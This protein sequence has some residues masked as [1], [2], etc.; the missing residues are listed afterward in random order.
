M[1]LQKKRSLRALVD[2]VASIGP[3]DGVPSK[4]LEQSQESAAGRADKSAMRLA[5]AVQR[6]LT[7]APPCDR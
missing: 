1:V 4:I 7:L 5:R 2:F 6:H 3:D